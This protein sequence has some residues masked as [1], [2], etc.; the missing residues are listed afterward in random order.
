MSAFGYALERLLIRHTYDR[1]LVSSS[2]S[3][4]SRW[5]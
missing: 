5:C 3:G 2:C 1:E 4:S